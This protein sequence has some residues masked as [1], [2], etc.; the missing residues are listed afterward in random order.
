MDEIDQAQQLS[1]DFAE[2][3]IEANR[4]PLHKLQARQKCYNCNEPLEGE[5]LFCDDD[6]RDDWQER[7][8]MIKGY[9]VFSGAS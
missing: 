1:Q 8:N 2:R 5:K 4:R 9:R 7:M 3:A 6:C